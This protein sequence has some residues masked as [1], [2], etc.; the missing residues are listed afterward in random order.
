MTLWQAACRLS[1]VL[2]RN[3]RKARSKS[4]QKVLEVE[5]VYIADDPEEVVIVSVHD[6]VCTYIAVRIC[7]HSSFAKEIINQ[8]SRLTY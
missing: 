4:Q 2:I 5:V 8:T 6:P 3:P 1:N 7:F